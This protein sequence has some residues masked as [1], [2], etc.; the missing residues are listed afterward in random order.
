MAFQNIL[1]GKLGTNPYEFKNKDSSELSFVCECSDYLF[2][3]KFNRSTAN[4]KK[5]DEPTVKDIIANIKDFDIDAILKNLHNK[6]P[7][8][9]S[10]KFF[11]KD[12]ILQSTL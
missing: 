10:D 6:N 9:K 8:L 5:A 11:T 12:A 2:D 3:P 7:S 4:Y 1:S